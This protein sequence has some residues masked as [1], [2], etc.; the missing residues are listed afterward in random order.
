MYFN[1]VMNESYGYFSDQDRFNELRIKTNDYIGLSNKLL[2]DKISNLEKVFN[3]R[4]EILETTLQIANN[5][6][7]N[8]K[9]KIN[10]MSLL[11]WIKI[12]FFGLKI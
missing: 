12:K 6:L 10:K 8:I 1:I 9:D 2:Y 4:I 11:T 3:N 7:Q 5:N